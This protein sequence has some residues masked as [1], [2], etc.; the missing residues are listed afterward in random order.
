MVFGIEMT[1]E[2]IAVAAAAIALLVPSFCSLF[3][4]LMAGLT[5]AG[6]VAEG[7]ENFKNAMILQAMP[8]T[9]TIYGFIIALFVV[10]AAGFAGGMGRSTPLGAGPLGE[11]EPFLLLGIA[12]LFSI[13]ALSAVFQGKMASAGITSCSK[14]PKALAP[15]L[16]FTG[17]LETPAIFGFVIAVV[18]LVM[19]LG[20]LG[21]V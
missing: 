13:T 15:N 8:Q 10:M 18:V 14:N 21:G 1:P 5:G 12:V 7:D 11:A 16:V 6:V 2:L 20:A 17:Q 4:L 19:G 3:A 9:Q